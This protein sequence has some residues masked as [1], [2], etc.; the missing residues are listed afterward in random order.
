[1][2]VAAASSNTGGGGGL[3]YVNTTNWHNASLLGGLSPG[4]ASALLLVVGLII[5]MIVALA[6]GR[7][8]WG[9][10]KPASA[11]PWSGSKSGTG[12]ANECPVCKQTFDTPEALKDHQ[13][14]AHGMG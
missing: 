13:K 5:G 7:M 2:T 6:L 8:M 10:G 12:G 1:V 4:V 9:G 11:Q 14:Q 3:T